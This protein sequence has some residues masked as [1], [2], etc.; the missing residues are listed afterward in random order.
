LTADL[1]AAGGSGRSLRDVEDLDGAEPAS[2]AYRRRVAG[3]ITVPVD[4]EGR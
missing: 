2:T 3:R 4:A 1:S